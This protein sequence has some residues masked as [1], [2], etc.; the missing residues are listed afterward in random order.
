MLQVV[1]EPEV[2]EDEPR[3][4]MMIGASLANSIEHTRVPTLTYSDQDAFGIVKKSRKG[5][6]DFLAW[7]KEQTPTEES[8]VWDTCQRIEYYGWLKQPED[9]AGREWTIAQIRQ[10]LFG[11]E[12]DG[13]AV[14]ILF[15]A[16]AWH[17]LMRTAAGLNSALPGDTDVTAQ[18]QTAC[19]IAERTA[20]AGPRANRLVEEAVEIAQRVQAETTWGR[21]CTG[22]CFAA[23]SRLHEVGGARF[24]ECRHVVIG[25]STTS[26]SVVETLS[27]HFQVPHRQMTLVYRCNHGQMKLLRS[28]IGNGKRLRVN[29]YAERGVIKAIADADFVFFGIDHPE[30][31]L[32]ATELLGLRDYGERPLQIVDFNSFGSLSDFDTRD[33][34]SIWSAADLDRAVAAYAEIL[35]AREQFLRAV[36]EAEEWIE[37]HVPTAVEPAA[38]E[39]QAADS[40]GW[41]QL[42]PEAQQ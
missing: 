30:P 9:I 15:G 23:L 29:S 31:V 24:N 17:H 14:N 11:S 4:L 33:G 28:A 7:V 2:T 40:T 10:R 12:P 16:Q 13:L 21:F 22:Y 41:G 32:D 37:R 34:L 38:H 20:T 35:G 8:F 27:D 19:R 6:F 39:T 36:V 5:L 1:S 42:R 25:G 26:R 18:L 3:S